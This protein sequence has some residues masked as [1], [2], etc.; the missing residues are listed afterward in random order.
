MRWFA[1]LFAVSSSI[2]S[3][4]QKVGIDFNEDMATSV[5]VQNTT[6]GFAKRYS[7]F[8]LDLGFALTG[9]DT[10]PGASQV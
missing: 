4:S 9:T 8:D 5:F 7:D 3:S 10:S 1:R 2:A 6:K